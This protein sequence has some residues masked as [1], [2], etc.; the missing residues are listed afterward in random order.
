MNIAAPQ[1]LKPLIAKV[2]N[3]FQGQNT[4][5]NPESISRGKPGVETKL[6]GGL[7]GPAAAL[8]SPHLPPAALAFL[9]LVGALTL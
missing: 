1:N 8:T 4:I 7:W 9:G 5:R 3:R 6:E 2:V